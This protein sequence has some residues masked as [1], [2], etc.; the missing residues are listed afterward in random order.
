LGN[1]NIDVDSISRPR[2]PGQ[3]SV[4]RLTEDGVFELRTERQ[5]GTRNDRPGLC[6]AMAQQRDDSGCQSAPQKF[7]HLVGCRDA[8]VCADK[9]YPDRTHRPNSPKR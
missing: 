3:S 2:K 5:D 9:A 7:V 4:Q 8:T 6:G 1:G